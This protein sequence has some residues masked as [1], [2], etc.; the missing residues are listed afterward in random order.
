M[1]MLA[2]L[3]GIN[4]GGNRKVPMKDLRLMAEELGLTEVETYINSGNLM[5]KTGHKKTDRVETLL[6]K[7]IEEKFG[8]HV[9]VIVRTETDW[10]KYASKT[11]FA[12]AAENR[13]NLLMLGLSKKACTRS[14]ATQL[15]E[16]ASENENIKVSQGALWIDFGNGVGKSKL[17]PLALEKAV[18]APVTLR[19]WKTVL[20]LQEMFL[21]E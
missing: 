7:K 1:K 3:R 16:R 15:S 21:G 5:F 2:L 20:K 8:F 19:N 13:P 14:A 11:P 6:E 9:D 18:G 17:T 10:K 12:E 4:V